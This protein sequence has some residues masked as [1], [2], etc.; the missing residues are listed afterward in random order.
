[1]S[2]LSSDMRDMAKY[3]A[4]SMGLALITV[5]VVVFWPC[6]GNG[7][8]FWDDPGFV[9]ENMA[10]RHGGP[11]ALAEI[12]RQTILGT[13]VPLATLSHWLEY[14]LFGLK[15]LVYHLVNLLLHAANVI[16]VFHLG[17]RLRLPRAAAFWGAL[18]FGI[19]PIHV[20]AVAWVTARKD[21][22]FT[23][24]YLAS[25]LA[26][27]RYIDTPRMRHYLLAW[28]LGLLSILAKPMALS[29]VLV[30]GVLD[31]YAGR[32]WSWK[33]VAE[34][35]PFLVYLVPVAWLT[36]RLHARIPAG[37]FSSSL[38]TWLWCATFY[39]KKFVWPSVLLPIY[40]IP[41]HFDHI[42]FDVALGIFIVVG[43]VLIRLRR[44]RLVVFSFLFYFA[45]IFFL[46]RFDRHRDL[47]MVAD[48]F[49]YLPSVG[50]CWL[51]GDG[52][53]RLGALL[54][55]KKVLFQRGGYAIIGIVLLALGLLSSRQC[56]LW[57]DEERMW[58]RALVYYPCSATYHKLGDYFYL[59][60]YY[61]LALPF[62]LK[63]YEA[64][65]H[66][67]EVLVN[68]A[69]IY[70]E[71]FNFKNA[72]AALNRAIALAPDYAVA[73]VNRGVLF[74]KMGQIKTAVDDLSRAIELDP[75]NDTAYFNRGMAFMQ[76]GAYARSE[77]DL[78]RVV[79]IN[80]RDSV[81]YFNLGQLHWRAGKTDQARAA[82]TRALAI[83]PS[84]KKAEAYVQRLDEQKR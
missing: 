18:L 70:A 5:T 75:N 27:I 79:A 8:T 38:M 84:F 78:R 44:H 3:S 33:L 80:P 42:D 50:F 16:L 21:V 43:A 66:N 47:Q 19:H 48:R 46:L 35:I 25:M 34:K 14:Q 29:L 13:Y 76:L 49:M 65:T 36:Y 81:A 26:Y 56:R 63:A 6:L 83:E 40:L 60:D 67:F 68:M 24:F 37:T 20:E 4:A 51:A 22:L 71:R 62:Y 58:R 59:R 31:W 54:K 7:F 55:R 73:Y 45:T 1:M 52:L 77:E 30:L 64:N 32:R 69:A 28:A 23:F 15:P 10:L 74:S 61:E 72:M 57:G 53:R 17:M 41:D 2:R 11:Q 12:F 9:T 39:L 82:F